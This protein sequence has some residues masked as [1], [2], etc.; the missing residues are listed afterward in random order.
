MPNQQ[1]KAPSRSI[2]RTG[3]R[4]RHP[5]WDGGANVL[6]R[7]EV[8]MPAGVPVSKRENIPLG[9][10]TGDLNRMAEAG[11]QYAMDKLEPSMASKPLQTAHT[12]CSLQ[13]TA[14]TKIGMQLLRFGPWIAPADY[15]HH[16]PVEACITLSTTC[17]SLQGKRDILWRNQ[18]LPR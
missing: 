5:W 13:A 9:H 6:L 8:T 17:L 14:P 7:S 1:V 12:I 2:T 10:D 16:Y 11:P 15:P 18:L 4:R 3:K